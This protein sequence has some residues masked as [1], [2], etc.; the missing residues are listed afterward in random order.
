[1]YKHRWHKCFDNFWHNNSLNGMIFRW[2]CT[3]NLS[4]LAYIIY[5]ENRYWV[6]SDKSSKYA[7]SR[8]TGAHDA[9]W[10]NLLQP[11]FSTGVPRECNKVWLD[12]IQL[13]EFQPTW[14]GFYTGMVLI[15]TL[16]F[17]HGMDGREVCFVIRVRCLRLI[18]LVTC[19]CIKFIICSNKKNYHGFAYNRYNW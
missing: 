13:T 6:D 8:D 12:N 18:Y 1:M 14:H 10:I 5:S 19:T 2:L 4:C 3:S 11:V 17:L 15:I 7:H 9:S 16:E